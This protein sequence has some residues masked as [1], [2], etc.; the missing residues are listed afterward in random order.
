MTAHAQARPYKQA[1][2]ILA[3]RGSTHGQAAV[4]EKEAEEEDEEAAVAQ[5]SKQ[6]QRPEQW[7]SGRP[8]P[9]QPV[10]DA[11]A[12]PEHAAGERQFGST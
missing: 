12:E 10:H 5:I 2:G 4:E 9:L 7:A 3:H 1:S 8:P 11:L 6:A